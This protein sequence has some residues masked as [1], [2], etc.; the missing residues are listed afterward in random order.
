MVTK[1]VSYFHAKQLFE[2]AKR[3]S[4]SKSKKIDSAIIAIM[5]SASALEAFI[6]ETAGL[7]RTIATS[8]RQPM[9]EGYMSVMSELEEKK[10]SILVKYHMGL[11]V[12]SGATWNEGDKVFQ[13]FK[14]LI[15]IR[16]AIV[17]MKTDRWETP[18]SR[19]KPDPERRV[20]QYPKFIKTLQQ[21]NVISTPDKSRS[22]IEL[23]GDPR[24]GKWACETAEKIT[25]EFAKC[26]PDG[27]FKEDL[28][29]HVFEL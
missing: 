4:K 22:W 24:V 28:R 15:T 7:A 20:D 5:F 14:L 26:A 1:V 27:Q 21:M 29:N 10:E 19:E 11:L 25:Q 6:N 9:V 16:N 2:I 23:L 13:N 3:A 18:V 17:H 12:F 8:K